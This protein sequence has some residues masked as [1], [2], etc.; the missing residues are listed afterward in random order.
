MVLHLIAASINT[1]SALRRRLG[2][3]FGFTTLLPPFLVPPEHTTFRALWAICS[4]GALLRNLDLRGVDWPL[5]K[6]LSHATSIVDTRR[7]VSTY[8]SLDAVGFFRALGWGVVAIAG[9]LAIA[10]VGS[11]LDAVDWLAR[12][13]SG[14]VFVYAFAAAAFGVAGVVY[15][16]AGFAPPLLHVSPA[17]SS[18]VQEFWG[19]RWNRIVSAWFGDNIFRPLARRRHPILGAIASFAFSAILHAYIAWVA[20]GFAM[21]AC[22]VVFFLAQAVIV[23]LERRLSVRAWAPFYGHVWTIAWMTLLSPLFVEGTVRALGY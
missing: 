3:V 9:W 13:L 4:V 8:P 23:L 5:R 19:E 16:L 7:L 18:S 1:G 21:A 17:L 10:R 6:R 11:P 2:L 22:M 15:R 14:L 20:V 12:W